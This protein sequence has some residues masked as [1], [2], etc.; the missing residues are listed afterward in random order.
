MAAARKDNPS[1]VYAGFQIADL[2]P[3]VADEDGQILRRAASVGTSARSA[4]VCQTVR[5]ELG[6]GRRRDPAPT[7]PADERGA[8]RRECRLKW[9]TMS[10]QSATRRP[11]TK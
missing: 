11:V 8:R 2:P 3:A 4:A 9:G 5:A 10:R 7:R 1:G 6:G